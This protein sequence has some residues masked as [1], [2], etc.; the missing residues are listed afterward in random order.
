MRALVDQYFEYL[1]NAEISNSNSAD[2]LRKESKSLTNALVGLVLCHNVSPVLT[3]EGRELQAASPDELALV[4]FAESLGFSIIDRSSHEITVVF[5][6]NSENTFK[7]LEN[8]VFSSERKRM[9]II[10]KHTGTGEITFYVKGADSVMSKIIKKEH[11]ELISEASREISKT[12]LRSLVLGQREISQ[13]EYD[14]WKKLFTAA[15]QNLKCRQVEEEKLIATLESSLELAGLTGVEDILQENVKSAISDLRTA[16]IKVWMLTGDKLET[17]QCISI[18]TGFKS[19][20]QNF[21]ILNDVKTDQIQK[22]LEQFDP[23]DLL[24]VPGDTLE[25]ILSQKDLCN[26]F[27]KKSCEAE[28]VILCRCSPKQKSEIVSILK[29]KHG[30]TVC[31]VGDG[32]NDVGMIQCSSIGIGIE[33]KEGMQAS[34]ASDFSVVKFNHLLTLILSYGRM[35]FVRTSRMS[36]LIIHRSMVFATLQYLFMVTSYFDYEKSRRIKEGEKE[37]SL[38]NPKLTMFFVVFFSNFLLM[39]TS[40]DVDIT[41]EKALFNPRL[42]RISQSGYYFSYR[43]LLLWFFIAVGQGSALF[44]V[45]SYLAGN[46]Y[47]TFVTISYIAIVFLI[48]L[49]I[50]SLMNKLHVLMWITLAFNLSLLATCVVFLNKTFGLLNVDATLFGKCITVVAVTWLPLCF[51]YFIRKRFFKSV[52]DYVLGLFANQPSSMISI[53]N[54]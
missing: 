12:G 31:A 20:T 45:S 33:G 41:P 52:S 17:A 35:S 15:Q 1:S 7:I 28:S 22:R 46:D 40:L 19:E 42:Y 6:D 47:Q 54:K 8:F 13:S 38:Y 25:L 53:V 14:N 51:L 2:I 30:K 11:S 27:F 3:D 9:G 10:V 23:Q 43:N 4:K 16:G 5:P 29:T 26:L 32:G 34:L 50:F 39:A 18:S 37:L 48:N 24:V 36:N 44:F 21:Y 49:N